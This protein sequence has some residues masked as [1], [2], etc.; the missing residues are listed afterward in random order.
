MSH[1]PISVECLIAMTLPSGVHPEYMYP[2]FMG[3]SWLFTW[4][5]LVAGGSLRTGTRPTLNLLLLPRASM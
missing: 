5:Q 2:S 1:A 4:K 3:G